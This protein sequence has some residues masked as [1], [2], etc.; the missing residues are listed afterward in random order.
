MANA[1]Q[2]VLVATAVL[3]G[4]AGVATFGWWTVIALL[5]AAGTAGIAAW[6]IYNAS[7]DGTSAMK[8]AY[9]LLGTV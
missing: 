5:S 8:E 4:A 9:N 7:N 3:V 6:E 2:D 1:R